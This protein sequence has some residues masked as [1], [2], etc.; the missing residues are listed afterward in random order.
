MKPPRGEA[1]NIRENDRDRGASVARGS[2]GEPPPRHHGPVA[3]SFNPLAS[4]EL[5]TSRARLP[6][7]DSPPSPAP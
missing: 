4:V 1:V 5:P 3:G 7:G 2:L 6:A